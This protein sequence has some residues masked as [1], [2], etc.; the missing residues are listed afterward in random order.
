VARRASPGSFDLEVPA[1]GRTAFIDVEAGLEG[2]AGSGACSFSVGRSPELARLG[3][4]LPGLSRWAEA[5]H[6]K[7]ETM[8]PPALPLTAVT[9]RD[10]R[11]L[12]PW[13]LLFA[14]PLFLLDLLLKRMAPG[15]FEGRS[16]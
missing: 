10:R 3:A 2:E 11:E 12:S 7:V 5:L 1:D 4:D 8:P 13:W 6:G 15:S 14:I 16:G 9:T